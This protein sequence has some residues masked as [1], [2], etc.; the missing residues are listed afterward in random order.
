MENKLKNR[1]QPAKNKRGRPRFNTEN[2]DVEPQSGLELPHGH[3]C[4]H[5]GAKFSTLDLT[6]TVQ[7]EHETVRYF[8]CSNR[9]C[10][11]GYKVRYPQ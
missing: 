2:D 4:I 7:K 10:Q 3:A 5:C 11:W 6:T 1:M 8:R 9:L